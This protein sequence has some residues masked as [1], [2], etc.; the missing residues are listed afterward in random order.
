[1]RDTGGRFGYL[2]ALFD[3]LGFEEKLRR[4][5]LDGI[6]TAYEA[7]IANI[8]RRNEQMERVFGPMGFTEAPYWTSEGD[9]FIFNKVH[10]AFASDSLLVWS[11]RT[12]PDARAKSVEELRELSASGANG[13]MAQPIPGDNFLDACS[14]LICHSLEI[15]LPVRGAL[16]AGSAIFD[17][18]RRVFLGQP[19]VDV[20]RLERTQVCISAAMC[21]SIA[22]QHIP[23]RYLLRYSEHLKSPAPNDYSG[24]NLDW[25]RHW[26]KTR[27]IDARAV[28]SA[29]NVDPKYSAYYENTL[30]FIDF[31]NSLAQQHETESDISVR[32][33]YPQFAASE[34]EVRAFA[35]RR[36][37]L[38]RPSN[39]I[40]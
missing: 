28:V 36:V 13:W 1:M 22:T 8:E 31:S 10:G 5:G 35:V 24:L 34:L 3:V 11:H 40:A 33:Q 17:D 20:A 12:W 39:K 38:I 2:V 14:D 16:A 4:H 37:P 15:G 29:L 19:I 9:V 30:R 23:H 27:R 21:K 6:A 26:R 25:P 7:L 32:A 18:E